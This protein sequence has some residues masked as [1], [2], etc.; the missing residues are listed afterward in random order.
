MQGLTVPS[1]AVNAITIATYKKYALVSLIYSGTSSQF[2][3]ELRLSN[4]LHGYSKLKFTSIPTCCKNA[5]SR[6]VANA[7]KQSLWLYVAPHSPCMPAGHVAALPKF[8]P[9]AVT[10]SIKSDAQAYTDLATAYSSQKPQDLPALVEQRRDLFT[11][12]II[13]L[14]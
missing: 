1:Y 4:D 5:K 13:K 12:V 10:R 9:S 2:V 6:S 8:T 3:S 7:M 11:E 14:S